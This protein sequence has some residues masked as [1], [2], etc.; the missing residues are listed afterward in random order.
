MPWVYNLKSPSSSPDNQI[1]LVLG[2]TLACSLAACAAVALRF[3]IRVRF[4]KA[5]WAD[6]YAALLSALLGMGYA[7]LAVA[8][9]LPAFPA[10]FEVCYR[11]GGLANGGGRDALGLRAS[12][13]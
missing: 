7:G 8:R 9:M 5:V 13:G 1:D 6:D 4:K 2:I 10:V 12:R 3:Y 11:V